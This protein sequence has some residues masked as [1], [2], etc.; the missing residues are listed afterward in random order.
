MIDLRSRRLWLWVGLFL[1]FLFA[2]FRMAA[3]QVRARIATKIDATARQLGLR[4]QVDDIHV[5][6]FPP[7]KLN[8]IS[9]DKP[10]QWSAT[11]KSVA[12]RPRFSR[13]PNGF[14]T[15]GRISVDEA[16]VA[17]PADFELQSHPSVWDIDPAG[18]I[19]LI[20]PVQGLTVTAAT[21]SKGNEITVRAT[22]LPIDQLGSLVLEGDATHDVGSVDGEARLES[23]S[24]QDFHARWRFEALGAVTSGTAGSTP[25][26]TEPRVGFAIKFDGLDFSKLFNALSID[27]TPKDEALG[28]LSG[29]M[30][31]EG[32]LSD[33][34]TL[35]ITQEF[36]FTPPKVLPAA[37]ANLRS[38]FTHEVITNTGRKRTL[39][40]SSGSPDFIALGDVPARL[41]R[42]LLIAED[43]AFFSHPGVDFTELPKVIAGN[44]AKGEAARGGSTITQQLA[45]NLFLTREKSLRRKLK[46]LAF[47][48]LLES[49]LG[50]QRILEIYLNIIEWGPGLYGLRPAS[51]HYFDKDPWDLTP[52][53]IAFLIS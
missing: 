31:T 34:D 33:P 41:I 37:L 10:G 17:L 29:S 22:H 30:S 3:D 44:I 8:G 36:K 52:K 21:T 32:V 35:Q 20:S 14:T 19:V 9:I 47:T 26:P 1:T 50:K 46:E 2:G 51:Y 53:E 25:G 27:A 49:S 15:T 5:G 43:A 23:R 40:V 38:G 45:K 42:T 11:I 18:S 28:T 16:H 4:I 39:Q 12:M 7:V 48:F 13:G 24:K 6:L